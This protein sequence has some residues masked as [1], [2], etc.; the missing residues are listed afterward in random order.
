MVTSCDLYAPRCITTVPQVRFHRSRGGV[1]IG[2]RPPRDPGDPACFININRKR[3]E[4][5]KKKREVLHLFRCY[6]HTP[7]RS[8]VNPERQEEEKSGHKRR[9]ND[10]TA[11]G[12]RG[13]D[14]PPEPTYT[15]KRTWRKTGHA[16]KPHDTLRRSREGRVIRDQ[17]GD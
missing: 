4:R 7:N 16:P 17:M 8:R 11:Q 5:G 2:H 10:Q 12:G 3:E 1:F 15:A 9:A 14:R 13:T 6:T